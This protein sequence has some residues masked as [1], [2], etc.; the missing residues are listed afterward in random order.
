[1]KNPGSRTGGKQQVRD[2]IRRR[3][4]SH[5]AP[6]AAHAA[7]PPPEPAQCAVCGAVYL[8][9]TWRRSPARLRAAFTREAPRTTCP[10]CA[11]VRAG[12]YG[13][14][15]VLRGSRVAP[16]ED[17]L[18]RRI[19]NVAARARF[20]Q[21]ERRLVSVQREG[22]GSLEV[23]TTSEKLAHRIV[24]EIEKA[25]GGRTCYVW[26]HRERSL[27]AIWRSDADEHKQWEWRRT[28]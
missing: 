23:R 28:S 16:Q 17:A 26:S 8:R 19:A 25:F 14:R 9:K 22:D 15:V 13:G 3:S 1:V 18:R 20:T 21:P 4:R 5:G 10:A 7:P 27:L 2:L 12:S 24:R 6:V 11:Q